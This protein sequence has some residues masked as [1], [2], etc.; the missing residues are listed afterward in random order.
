MKI[1]AFNGSPRGARGNTEVIL[2]AFLDG[3]RDAGEDAEV[4]YLKDKTINHCIGCFTCWIKT[5]GVCVHKDDMPELLDK[6]KDADI[7]IGALPLY[8]YTVPGLFK[9]FL[10]RL[11]PLIQPQIERRGDHFAHPSRY[12]NRM[13]MVLISNAGFPETHN[14]DA[15]KQTFRLLTDGPDSE[16]MGMICCAGGPLLTIPEMKDEVKWYLD[17]AKKAGVEIVK[18]GRIAPETQAILDRPLPSDPGAFADM[19][20]AYWVSLGVER[21]PVDEPESETEDT[22]GGTALPSPESVETIRDM[23]AGMPMAFNADEAGDLEA[24]VQFDITDEQPG[25]Y[26]LTISKGACKAYEGTHHEPTVTI[27]TP[28]DVW[29]KISRGELNGATAFMT[30]KFKVSGKMDLLMKMAKF[31]TPPAKS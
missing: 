31:F 22:A 19:V 21:I 30:G 23:I 9:D 26:Y 11:I 18:E 8:I 17:A 15:L 7:I 29:L 5:P 25:D 14:F 12:G 13:R 20:N 16:L 3:A 28:A 6:I 24:V 2:Q 4:I 27:K 10:D 1:I